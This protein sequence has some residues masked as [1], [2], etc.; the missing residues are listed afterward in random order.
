MFHIQIGRSVHTLE[1]AVCC[2][3]R[4]LRRGMRCNSM[5]KYQ[6]PERE[7]EKNVCQKTWR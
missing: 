5:K 6:S 3:G 2:I 1:R 4:N 7:G